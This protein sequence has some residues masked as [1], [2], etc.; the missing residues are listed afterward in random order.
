MANIKLTLPGEPFSGQIVTFTAP[1][2]CDKVT[3]GIVINTKIYTVCDAMGN[4]VTG[5]GGVWCAGAQVSVVLDCENRK[6]Y[7]QNGKATPAQI[8]AASNPHIEDNWYFP[9]PVNQRGQ[10]E[11]TRTSVSNNGVYTIDRWRSRNGKGSVALVEGGILI[12]CSATD[13]HLYFEQDIIPTLAEKSLVFSLLVDDI[14]GDCYAQAH[15]VGGGFSTAKTLTK[16]LASY[17]IPA[18]KSVDRI[19]IQ[20]NKATNAKVKL[21]AVKLEYGTVQTLAHQDED[22]NWVLNDVPNY[23]EELMK[24]C[25]NTADS[26]DTY[27]NNLMTASAFGAANADDH[28]VKFY[29]TLSHVGL[30]T[31]DFVAD[32][33]LANCIMV[34]N[35]LPSFSELRVMGNSSNNLTK[36]FLAK[37]NADTGLNIS[38]YLNI[39]FRKSTNNILEVEI[40]PQPVS[41]SGYEFSW[42]LRYT[43][44]STEVLSKTCI[45]RS[46]NGL[47]EA[48]HTH[49]A[50]DVTGVA[51]EKHTHTT[52]D[53]TGLDSLLSS[54][55]KIATGSYV[56]TGTYGKD[57]PNTLIFD[58]TPEVVVI[59]NGGA[60]MAT[61]LRGQS[62]PAH[63]GSFSI[64]HSCVAMWEANSLSWYATDMEYGVPENAQGNSTY[65]TYS[66]FALGKEG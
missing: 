38:A 51:K 49:T 16:G 24:C 8:G 48:N 1:C 58:F 45:T 53:I 32:D 12:E 66:W 40:T 52:S 18:G 59:T 5:T 2:D 10:T 57:N 42:V 6:A 29:T 14:E 26:S 30:D 15:Y 62:N 25:L 11:Y 36:S 37:I 20:L 41:W 39:T 65:S 61:F 3:G 60:G 44:G 56:G 43:E 64:G 7:I 21:R 50:D 33:A 28:N 19:L 9:N 31:S 34:I 55:S 63:L 23:A 46:P 13:Y 17:V 47:S 27:A 35:A 22:G 54:Y 4:K